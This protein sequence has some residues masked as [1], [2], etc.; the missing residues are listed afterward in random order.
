MKKLNKLII[1]CMM[2]TFIISFFSC[3]GDDE[4]SILPNDSY[5]RN[6]IVRLDS[7]ITPGYEKIIYSYNEQNQIRRIDIFT[8]EGNDAWTQQDYS[9][10]SYNADGTINELKQYERGN[11]FSEWHYIRTSKNTYNPNKTIKES[12]MSY[13]DDDK[14]IVF[15]KEEFSYNTK[16]QKEERLDYLYINHD[17]TWKLQSKTMF[18]YDEDGNCIQEIAS[19]WEDGKWVVWSNTVY[20]YDSSITAT[21]GTKKVTSCHITTDEDEYDSYFYYSEVKLNK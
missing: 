16:N 18:K 8:T 14:E 5:N 21:D 9:E 17:N 10:P 1:T 2:A 7:I 11:D 12:L 13:I 20:T 19:D 4:N 6:P 3:N 15:G